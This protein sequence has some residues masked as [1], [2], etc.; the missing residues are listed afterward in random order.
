MA[1]E[2]QRDRWSLSCRECYCFLFDI[3]SCQFSSED[4]LPTDPAA[5][6]SQFVAF[7]FSGHRLFRHMFKASQIQSSCQ[8]QTEGG[9]CCTA[10]CGRRDPQQEASSLP[11]V[12]ILLHSPHMH[13]EALTQ[14]LNSKQEEDDELLVAPQSASVPDANE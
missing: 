2:A 1:R 4:D 11:H 5:A 9:C 12:R 7:F 8:R 13:S 14:T 10:F 6:V 3:L